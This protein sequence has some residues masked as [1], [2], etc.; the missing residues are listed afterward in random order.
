M[1]V[2]D[3]NLIVITQFA[4]KGMAWIPKFTPVEILEHNNFAMAGV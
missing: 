1:E 4:K 3:A 2:T